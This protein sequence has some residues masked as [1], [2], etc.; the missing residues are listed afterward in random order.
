MVKLIMPM[1]RTT[2]TRRPRSALPAVLV[3]GAVLGVTIGLAFTV[4]APVPGIVSPGTAVVIG[5]PLS[6]ALLDLAALATVGL[7]LLPRLVGG[8]R[9]RQVARAL[10]RARRA[11]V[12]TAAVWLL[13]TLAALVF[14]VADLTPGQPV[15]TAAI[16]HYVWQ[17]PSGQAHAVVA[18]CALIYLVIAALAVRRGE[19]IPAG[20]RIT[21]A[22]FALL[23]L[24]VSGH[25]ALDA[26]GAWRDLTLICME[27]HVLSAVC[28]TGGLLAVLSLLATDRDTLAEALPRF[29]R[30]ATYC[31]CTVGITGVLNGW[32]QLADTPGIHWYMALFTTGYGAILIGK[33]ICI[34]SAAALGGYTRFKLLPA[35]AARRRTAV[36]TWVTFEVAVLGI[37]FGL[38][39]VLVRAPVVTGPP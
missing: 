16:A 20:L 14:E 11:A 4:T 39:A 13:A 29:S 33:I 5:L 22:L 18:C 26:P 21:V 24:P 34:G 7:S 23:P 10:D 35:I 37:A 36:L 19:A 12:V 15:T 28:W 6:R 17:I 30:L 9:N 27:L 2:T 3:C 32:F 38:A 1:T 8:E 31:V 25:A